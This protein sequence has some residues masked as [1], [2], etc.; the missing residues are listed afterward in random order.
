[1]K[2]RVEPHVCTYDTLI[3]KLKRINTLTIINRITIA[4]DLVKI[5]ILYI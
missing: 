4:G 3:Y 5:N 2:P 1:M